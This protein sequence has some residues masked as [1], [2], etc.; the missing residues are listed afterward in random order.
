VVPDDF[1]L[2]ECRM[3]PRHASALILVE[4]LVSLL[5]W[6]AVDYIKLAF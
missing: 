2:S 1:T 4:Y 5:I 6:Y 3:K